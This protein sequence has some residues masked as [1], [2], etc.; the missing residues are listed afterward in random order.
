MACRAEDRAGRVCR[1]GAG[2]S[3]RHRFGALGLTDGQCA[4]LQAIAAH[5]E[6]FNPGPSMRSLVA[7]GLVQRS[8]IGMRW[9]RYTLTRAGRFVVHTECTPSPGR[10][11]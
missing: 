11:A 7:L 4:A 8:F 6:H 5:P 10:Q 3:A 9:W 1:L 2:H